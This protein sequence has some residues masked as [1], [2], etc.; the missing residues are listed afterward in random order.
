[1]CSA[2]PEQPIVSS[3]GFQ[4][5]LSLSFI[6]TQSGPSYLTTAS[7]KTYIAQLI[8]VLEGRLA[9]LS[10]TQGLY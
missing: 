5:A 8:R 1:M 6:L 2:P 10:T 7:Q 9:P 3:D 4:S